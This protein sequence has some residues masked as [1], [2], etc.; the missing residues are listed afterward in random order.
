[1]TTLHAHN[2]GIARQVFSPLIFIFGKKHDQQY[3]QRQTVKMIP[4]NFQTQLINLTI[5]YC[6]I[7]NGI[8][9]PVFKQPV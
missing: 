1:M 7:T 3:P 5:S 4:A 8:S 9:M 6:R 2:I